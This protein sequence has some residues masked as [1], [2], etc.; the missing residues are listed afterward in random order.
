[1]CPYFRKE[2]ECYQRSRK[3]LFRLF[4]VATFRLLPK[5]ITILV[6]NTIEQFPLF[7]NFIWMGLHNTYSF[8]F[9][10]FQ[11][12]LWDPLSMCSSNLFLFMKLIY[13]NLCIVFG[14]LDHFQFDVTMSNAAV[15]ILLHVLWWVYI[16]IFLL[17]MLYRSTM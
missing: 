12:R 13:H 10:F 17:Y 3:T 15:S 4:P 7:L 16:H 11:S 8:R 14:Y 5:G 9:G 2:K 6:R 1:M